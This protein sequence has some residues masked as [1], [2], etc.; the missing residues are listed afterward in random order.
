VEI[1]EHGEDPPMIVRRREK[2]ELG[3]DVSD[4]CLDGLLR[5][6]EA[7]ADRL[8]RATLSHQRQDLEFAIRQLVDGTRLAP[9]TDEARNDIRVN[10]ETAA[11]YPADRFREI[12][13]VCDSV[14]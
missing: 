2:T 6:V 10:H 11:R 3:E 5:H 13:D 7:I 4:M 8:V 12:V 1:R 14:F 9:T